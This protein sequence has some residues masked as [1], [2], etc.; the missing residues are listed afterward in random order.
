[1]NKILKSVLLTAKDIALESA[2]TVIPGAGVVIS[3]V[4]KLV[5]HD[6][7][8]NGEAVTEIGEGVIVAVNSLRPDQIIDAAKVTLGVM[9]IKQGIAELKQGI[10]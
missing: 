9:H 6:N 2:S 1:M 7:S 10:K 5:D 3:G 4:Q 8:N